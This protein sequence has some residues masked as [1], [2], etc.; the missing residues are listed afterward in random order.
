M[1]RRAQIYPQVMATAADLIDGPVVTAPATLGAADAMRLARRREADV[2][3]AGGDRFI[4]R[5]D[6]ARAHALGL[7]ELPMARLARPL[8]MVNARESE[9]VVR[10]HLAAGAPAVVVLRGRS[11]IGVVR[12]TPPP[13]AISMRARIERWVDAESRGLLDAVGRLATEQGARAY[14]VGGVVR[15]AWLGREPGGHDLDVV[16]EGDARLVAR[17][18]AAALGGTLVEHERFLTASVEL[19]AGR[20]IDVVTARSERYE[21]PGALPHVMPASIAEDL[22]RRDF[23]V[24]AMAI[25]LGDEAMTLLDPLG[26]AADAAAQR[27]RIL[28]PL[29]FVE[30]PTRIFRAAR[31]AARL[32]FVLDP[33]TA[34]CR[35]LALELGPYTVLSPARIAA[36][37]DRI[38]AE[39]T[40]GAAL[41]ALARA[42]VFTL[43]AAKYRSTRIAAGRLEALPAAL[44]WGRARRASPPRLELVA[45]VLA[46][47][48]P[49]AV[50]DATLRALG[51]SGAP[52]ERVRQ[53][54]A[55][56]GTLREQ[57]ASTRRPSET[58]RL[59]RAAGPLAAA[60]LHLTGDDATRRRLARV[61]ADETA[62][63]SLGG[64]ALVTLGVPRGPELAVVLNGLRDARLDGDVGDRAGELD[65]V[66][67]WLATRTKEG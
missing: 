57:L 8:P 7:A 27:L 31:Y 26:G 67:R 51:L 15:D 16:V 12:R 17:A 11:A 10:R 41:A 34:K 23:T 63:P 4:L 18:L 50:G 32:G 38:L 22:R 49:Q 21:E 55:N 35:A 47:D 20:R 59:L 19:P 52:L 45:A 30:D 53:V 64:E 9:I 24:N 66:Q 65:Y 62:R 6:V 46:A 58:A 14:V 54:F 40:A 48:Q 39:R 13:V 61:G 28:H 5:A 44:E 36:E 56:A 33:W 37:L 25:A 1:A 2:L 60:W 29:S 42:G 3:G 43:L